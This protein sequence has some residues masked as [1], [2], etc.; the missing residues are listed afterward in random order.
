MSRHADRRDRLLRL[1]PGTGADGLLVTHPANVTYLTG[2]TGDS[3][4]L[5]L[6]PREQIMISDGR[7][8]QQLTEE[9]PDLD[10][11]IRR[12][13]LE[14]LPMVAK[15]VDAAKVRNL[16]IEAA[17]MTVAFCSELSQQLSGVQFT[18]TGSLVEGLREI[19]DREEV[20]QIREAIEL[21]E[22]AFAVVRAGLRPDHTEKQIAHNLEHQIRCFGGTGCSFTP[23]V[24]VGPRGALPHA[25]LSDHRVEE[26]D[27]VLID[28]G[29]RGAL[30]V[31]DLTRVLVTGRISPKL[32]RVYG[33][34]L[35]AQ[36]AAIA[37][38][39]PR[40]VLK[41]VDAVARKVIEE[42]GLGKYFTHGLGHGIG[43]EIHEGPRLAPSQ[44]RQLKAGMVVT[45]EPGVYLP[46]WGGVRIE[47]DILVT[48]T[49][50]EVL[51]HV[52]KELDDCVLQGMR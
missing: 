49:G 32:E 24:G 1:V 50:G 17:S 35:K 51:S 28:W 7:Y 19:K 4:Y 45:V 23:I 33:V 52:A 20:A 42:A 5:L 25:R 18:F 15:V 12:P 34:V 10:A 29:A 47:D 37:A 31:S 44:D 48:R 40:A 9:C 26:S 2:F 43:L 41:D 21:A 39:R 27:F 46:Q 30:Y 3:S 16:A 38:I 36:R 8:A 6:T 14:M 11:E 13:G 22:R